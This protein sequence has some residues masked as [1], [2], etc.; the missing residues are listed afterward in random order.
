MYLSINNDDDNYINEMINI[1]II[2]RGKGLERHGTAGA[3]I[4]IPHTVVN[5]GLREGVSRAGVA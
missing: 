5:F 1:V 3:E 2:I 4:F